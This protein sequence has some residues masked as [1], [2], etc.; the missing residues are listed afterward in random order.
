M[1]LAAQEH[2]LHPTT[3]LRCA[4]HHGPVTDC[5]PLNT[6]LGDLL[7]DLETAGVTITLTAQV[8]WLDPCTGCAHLPD[9]PA[10]DAVAVIVYTVTPRPDAY[11][12]RVTTCPGC[13]WP[14]VRYQLD[15]HATVTVEIP[16]AIGQVA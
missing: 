10:H 11:R 8:P 12:Y 2:T 1:D 16:A 3:T 5:P 14:E 15:R 13:L 6:E 9:F 4:L 7:P